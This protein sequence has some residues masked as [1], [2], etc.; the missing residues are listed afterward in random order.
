MIKI[1]KV[2]RLGTRRRAVLNKLYSDR[3][4]GEPT[5]WREI[6]DEYDAG[7]PED[8][9]QLFHN[10]RSHSSMEVGRLLWNF[11]DRVSRGKYRI[12]DEWFSRMNQHLGLSEK[13]PPTPEPWC[14]CKRY[15]LEDSDKF[16]STTDGQVHGYDWCKTGKVVTATVN[17]SE[18]SMVA[19]VKHVLQEGRVNQKL[20]DD[21][22]EAARMHTRAQ[23]NLEN[24][25]RN[26]S[27]VELHLDALL[28]D[29]RGEIDRNSPHTSK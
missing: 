11:A 5:L 12:K 17:L 1:T 23:E 29:A 26:F 6:K 7:Y 19:L 10:P 27:E 16:F 18:G 8:R 15:V 3:M 9:G 13:P 4:V 25:A 21:L 14:S 2:P 20:Q 24:A 22:L 28:R